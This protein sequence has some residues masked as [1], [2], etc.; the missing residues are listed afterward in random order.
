[1]ALATLPSTL[2]LDERRALQEL[3]EWLRAHF[4]RRLVDL[5]LFGSR[6]RS[7][8]HEDSDLDVLVVVDGMSG[9]ERLAIW[10]FSGK[11][12]ARHEVTVST[13]TVSA[14]R[15]HELVRERRAIVRDIERDGIP[16]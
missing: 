4:G 6:A 13:F 3:A 14:E 12:Q 8:G 5:R 10:F 2:R 11:L 7:E 15:W 9:D 16:L 1:M